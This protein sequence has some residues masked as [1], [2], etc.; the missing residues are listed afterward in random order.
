VT[1]TVESRRGPLIVIAG[2]TASG[3]TAV[4]IELATELDGEVIGA[5]S[6]Q[7]YRYLDI[8]TDKPTEE[9]LGGVAHHMIDLV[10][11]D[12]E[13]DVARFVG[14]ADVAIA[15][16]LRRGRRAIVAGGTGLYLRALLHGLQ[17]APGPDPELRAELTARAE[18]EGW[19]AL[20]EELESVDP[21]TAERLHENDGVRI[22]RALEVF[23]QTGEPMSSWQRRHRFAERRYPALV[24]GIERPREQLHSRID[25]RIE[26]MM[27]RGFLGEVRGLI[28]RGYGPEL[29]PMMGLG[30][31]RM[32]QHLAGEL[33]LDEAVAKTRSDT[34]RLARRQR[35]WFRDDP[36]ITWVSPEAGQVAGRAAR[37]FEREGKR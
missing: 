11:P 33:T 17:G 23:R 25:Q 31:R 10:D 16:V 8:G 30:Y 13:Y 22:L 15:D 5:D 36:E 32:C 6:M 26:E 14:D 12:E 27:R 18:R 19:P 7:V 34:K 29:K 20:H 1:V 9:E 24:L 3:K 37:F 2:P 21:E 4:A 28:E 35:T